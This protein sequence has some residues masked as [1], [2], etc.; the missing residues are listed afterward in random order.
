VVTSNQVDPL[1][2][3]NDLEEVFAMR[4]WRKLIE[5]AKS[6]LYQYQA[7][8]L[9]V[10]SWD[11]VNELR[12]QCLQLSRLINLEEVTALMKAQVLEEQAAENA[13]V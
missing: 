10:P 2:D 9:E 3:F 5:E 12:G 13:D 6:Q 4:G 11:K 7:D 8:A 1:E